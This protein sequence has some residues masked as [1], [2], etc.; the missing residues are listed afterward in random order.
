MATLKLNSYELF[1]QSENNGPM[2]GTGFPAGV[3]IQ[4]QLQTFNYSFTNTK[5][6]STIWEDT[7]YHVTISPFM[8]NSKIYVECISTVSHH[9]NQSTSRIDIRRYVNNTHLATSPHAGTHNGDG[10]TMGSY[11]N[12]SST[13]NGHPVTICW[14]DEHNQ[15]SGTPITYRVFL[16]GNLV[17]GNSPY[18]QMG[19][20]ASTNPTAYDIITTVKAME[21]TQ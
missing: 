14:Y 12:G 17:S 21:I 10:A 18:V 4:F 5:N 8:S 2:I 20:T 6:P 11:D 19:T 13:D 3:P 7:G 9:V 16:A 1:T 15:S